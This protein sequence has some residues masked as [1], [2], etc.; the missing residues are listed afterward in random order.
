MYDLPYHVL[1]H[2]KIKYFPKS[3]RINRPVNVAPH[4]IITIS[5]LVDISLACDLL[6]FPH[7]FPA[8]FLLGFF[9]F[10]RLSNLVP[11]AVGDFEFTRH[12]TGHDIF[13]TKKY[14]KV[15]I[16]LLKQYK[17]ETEC[18]ACSFPSYIIKQF[19]PMQ[20]SD[21]CSGCIPCH[22]KP[23]CFRFKPHRAGSP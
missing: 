14:V 23:H 7:V 3:L 20:L 17:P 6:T 12:L 22:V 9:A 5:R 16:K 19:V 18:N 8:A 15:M 11:H 4:N 2:P 13:F 1:D 21:N 10:L